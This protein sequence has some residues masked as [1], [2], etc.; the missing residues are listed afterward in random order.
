MTGELACP[1][2]Q[3]RGTRL[4]LRRDPAIQ[5]A[6]ELAGMY[7]YSA[8][9]STWQLQLQSLNELPYLYVPMY[10]GTVCDRRKVSESD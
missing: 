5:A 1:S 3:P 9:L 7:R 8:S 6:R 2:K 4:K 10:L